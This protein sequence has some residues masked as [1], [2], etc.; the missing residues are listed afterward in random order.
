MSDSKGRINPNRG[1]LLKISK[2]LTREELNDMKF[3]CHDKIAD[4]ELE[5]ITSVLE[6][7]KKISQ[8]DDTGDDGMSFISDL[9]VEVGR[10]DLSNELLGISN[11]GRFESLL[12]PLLF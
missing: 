10:K 11:D 12:I 3:V 7:F 1:L 9:L 6:L 8:L 4:G 2:K 5:K